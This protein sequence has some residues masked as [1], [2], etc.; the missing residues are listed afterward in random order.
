MN[1]ADIFAETMH[2]YFRMYP[3]IS[4]I[5]AFVL[6]SGRTMAYS[7]KISGLERNTTHTAVTLTRKFTIRRSSWTPLSIPDHPPN[8]GLISYKSAI[9]PVQLVKSSTNES[10]VSS[11][12][13]TFINLDQLS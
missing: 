5:T 12:D 4:E 3:P 10:Q 7:R 6:A 13:M 11:T 8:A 1:E 9:E 2:M